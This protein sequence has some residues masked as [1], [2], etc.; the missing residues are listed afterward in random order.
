MSPPPQTYIFQQLLAR[1]HYNC[2]FYENM[3]NPSKFAVSQFKILFK[4]ASQKL[5]TLNLLIIL[6][7]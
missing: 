3:K 5:I 7:P 1:Y 4:R 2:G 6:Y